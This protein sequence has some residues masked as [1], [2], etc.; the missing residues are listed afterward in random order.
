[1]RDSEPAR[2]AMLHKQA[3]A[4]ILARAIGIA[5]DAGVVAA[6]LRQAGKEALHPVAL[7][8]D[9][10]GDRRVGVERPGGCLLYTSRCV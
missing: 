8:G 1:M 9:G 7:G 3:M 2:L 6:A 5:G 10:R 4:E